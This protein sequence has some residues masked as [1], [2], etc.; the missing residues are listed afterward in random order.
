MHEEL[1]HLVDLL[2]EAGLR[3]ALE[4]IR[5]HA[6]GDHGPERAYPSSPHLRPIRSWPDAEQILASE[7]GR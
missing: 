7:P 5:A 3:L 1:H 6:A 2:P 4:L